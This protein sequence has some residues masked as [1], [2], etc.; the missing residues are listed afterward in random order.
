MYN[1]IEGENN[2]LERQRERKKK[3]NKAVHAEEK[4]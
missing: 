1:C 2:N 4:N 3:S